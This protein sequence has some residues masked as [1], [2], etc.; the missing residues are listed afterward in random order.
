MVSLQRYRD[1]FGV[2]AVRA[3]LVSSIVGRMP[4]GIAG[5]AILLFVQ[6]RSGSFALAGTA[7]ALYV[8]GLGLVAPFLGRLIDRLGP[9]PVLGSG[10]PGGVRERCFSAR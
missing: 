9:R 8:L 5:L 7:S 10:A 4:I 6:G 3:T 1:L 2:P